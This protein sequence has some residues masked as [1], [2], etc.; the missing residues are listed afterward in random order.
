MNTVE[1]VSLDEIEFDELPP[2]D[3][4]PGTP[5]TLVP[6]VDNPEDD[7][8]KRLAWLAEEVR[9]TSAEYAKK[10]REESVLEAREY[11]T[12]AIPCPTQSP[13]DVDLPKITLALGVDPQRDPTLIGRRTSEHEWD[14]DVSDPEELSRTLPLDPHANIEEPLPFPTRTHARTSTPRKR[15]VVLMAAL[16]GIVLGTVLH[17][18][19]MVRVS[20]D[21]ATVPYARYGPTIAAQRALERYEDWLTVH[22]LA[23]QQANASLPRP[24]PVVTTTAAPPASS[25]T[26]SPYFPFVTPTL[27]AP[28]PAH[29]ENAVPKTKIPDGPIFNLGY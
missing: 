18:A 28:R 21:Y 13:K 27:K 2:T 24:A 9:S 15:F 10:K 22:A 14:F 16:G 7:L 12:A 3:P 11:K 19:V 25:A 8:E 26:H 1:E 5:I 29:S 23:A 20:S 6:R 17:R 4:C